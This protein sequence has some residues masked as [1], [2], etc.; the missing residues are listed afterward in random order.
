[1]TGFTEMDSAEVEW[2]GAAIQAAL[3]HAPGWHVGFRIARVSAQ[4]PAADASVQDYAW[5]I[6]H[7][8]FDRDGWPPGLTYYEAFADAR[9][10]LVLT[11]GNSDIGVSNPTNTPQKALILPLAHVERLLSRVLSDAG[12][13]PPNRYGYS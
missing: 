5:K 4:K 7:D 12:T 8:D 2:I 9:G 13:Y 1:M 3:P 11:Y 6:W 10:N